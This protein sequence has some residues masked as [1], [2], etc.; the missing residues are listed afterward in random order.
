MKHCYL[1]FILFVITAFPAGL[2]AQ[3]SEPQTKDHKVR[4]GDSPTSIANLYHMSKKD[5]LEINA[6][7]DNVKL[8][9]GQTVKVIPHAKAEKSAKAKPAKEEKTSA[10]KNT[11][12]KE[13]KEP[14][15]KEQAKSSGKGKGSKTKGDEVKFEEY[16]VK[17]DES[18]SSIA[19]NNNIS[20]QD[21]LTINN[22]KKNVKLKT[23]QMV[24]IRAILEEATPPA[25]TTKAEEKPV[26]AAPPVEATPPP[27]GKVEEKP[28]PVE[29]KPAPAE[30]SE[31]SNQLAATR[32][33]PSA[34]NNEES[35]TPPPAKPAPA[36]K[37]KPAPRSAYS[38]DETVGPDGTQYTVS[39][40]G[41]HVVEKNQTMYRIS[42]IYHISIDELM[43]INNLS[44]T[45]LEIGQ[46]LK[47]TR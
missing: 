21:F 39:N 15:K 33:H 37:P 12:K 13:K 28:A 1:L 10:K 11:E 17:K 7:P 4:K 3:D 5:F 23:G 29:E 9:A 20:E 26:E 35:E 44:T 41:Y 40:D 31:H 47:V 34:G 30:N 24:K 22:F 6:F 27:A 38:G 36:P 43:R 2:W 14:E 18:P 46:K 32:K 16:K 19:A 42:R 45:N 25:E 8:I